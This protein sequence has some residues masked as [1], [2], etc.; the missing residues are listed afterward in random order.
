MFIGLCC[1]HQGISQLHIVSDITVTGNQ[2][3]KDFVILRECPLKV[4]DSL[5]LTNLEELKKSITRNIT[6]TGLTNFVDISFTPEDSTSVNVNINILERWYIWPNL[7]FELKETNFNS[8]WESKDFN[9]INYGFSIDDYNF[10][11]RQEKLSIRFQ[12]GW[13]RKIGINYQIPGLNKKRT[14]GGGIEIY[15][16][17]NR[18]VNHQM[19]FAPDSIFNKRNFLKTKNIIQEEMVGRIKVE[20][21][22]RYLNKHRWIAGIETV[23]VSDTVRDV[24]PNYLGNSNRRSQYFYLSY[25]FKRETRDNRAYP[26]TGYLIDGSIDQHGLGILN[27]NDVILTDGIV[28]VNSHHHIKNRWYFGHGVK[29]KATIFGTPPYYFQRGLG[30][31][32]TNIRG[33]ELYVIDGQHFGLYRSNL[34]YQLIKKNTIDLKTLFRKFDKFH[35]SLFLNAFGDAGYAIDKINASTNPLANELQYSFGL[36]L[37]FVSYYDLVIRFEGSINALKEPGFYINFTKPI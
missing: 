26:L 29:I 6:N 19:Q 7:I 36:G 37:D 20:Y 28:T 21:R 13:T 23:I 34:K 8:W 9:R 5:D 27:K 11:G 3:T 15:Y 1:W 16:S 22:P 32:Q 2:R 17:N 25:G 18:E 24:N 10:R 33:Y 30:Y 31:G 4:G 12:N 35:Y 14:L